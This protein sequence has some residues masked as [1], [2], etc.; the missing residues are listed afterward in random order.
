MPETDIYRGTKGLF[1][2]ESVSNEVIKGTKYNSV[3]MNLA[4]EIRLPGSGVAIP[5]ITGEAEAEWV[6][7]ET[8]ERKVSKPTFGNKKIKGYAM[9]VIVPFSDAFRRDFDVLYEACVEL[10][11]SALAKTF[12]S[13]VFGHTSAPG[14]SFTQ[15]TNAA[16]A[17]VE[18]D[19]YAGFV[20]ADGI[21]SASNAMVNGW[22]ASP[23]LRTLMLGAVDG[24]K[25]PLFIANATT[26]NGVGSMFGAG[27]HISEKVYKAGSPNVLGFAGDWSKAR[28]GIVGG[29]KISLADESSITIDGSTINLWQNEMFAVRCSFEAGFVH[30]DDKYFAKLVG[31]AG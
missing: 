10:L 8:G 15:L 29:V 16:T 1:L 18:T 30:A 6:E 3:V 9:S 12:D 2:P 20:A 28:W 13:T 7:G 25:R 24:N 23:Q 19:P 21:V 5:M 11:P 14:E 26:E 17:D 22:I 4:K 31:K 27:V